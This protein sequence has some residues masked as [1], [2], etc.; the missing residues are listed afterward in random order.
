MSPENFKELRLVLEANENSLEEQ[1][2]TSF[3]GPQQSFQIRNEG[4]FS[5]RW[6]RK[7][8]FPP[9]HFLGTLNLRNLPVTV[10]IINKG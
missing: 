6:Q 1:A 7:P 2:G 10:G 4:F 8:F 5:G 3:H 9:R